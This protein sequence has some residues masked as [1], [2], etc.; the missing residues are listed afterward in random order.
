MSSLWKDRLRAGG[1]HFC[2]SLGIAALAALLVFA[3]WYPG[4][5]REIAGGRDL[6]LLLVAVDVAL[7]P[8][9]TLVIFN[10]NKP[11]KVLR[12]DLAVIGLAQL[13]ALGYGM[14]TVYV[15]R[16]VHL[17]FE[18][19]RFR[20]VHAI[21]IPAEMADRAPSGIKA[22]PI[23]GP[24]LLALR[25]FRDADEKF[26][27]TMAALNG[28]SLSAQPELWQPYPEARKSILEAAKPVTALKTRFP[29]RAAEIDK[30]LADAGRAAETVL[31]LPLATRKDFGTIL[32]DSST[33]EVLGFIPLDS[34]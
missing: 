6:F 26:K 10:R 14:W 25:P 17:V 22:R 11:W 30:A 34:F 18:Y 16:P 20:V 33:A 23:T 19:D 3:V 5:Y 9:I 31:Y 28:W 4:Y 1:L 13:A 29:D 21:D 24:T 12:R 7:G 27:T 2:I 8:M 15:A 32:V